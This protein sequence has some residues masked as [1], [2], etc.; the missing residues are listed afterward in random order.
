MTQSF[1]FKKIAMN[2]SPSFPLAIILV[3][4]CFNPLHPPNTLPERFTMNCGPTQ[5]HT[6]LHQL[7]Y[8]I[9]LN[10]NSHTHFIK[11]PAHTIRSHIS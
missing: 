10:P 6:Q 9:K 5:N 1:F 2:Y 11:H 8:P 4:F 3:S 7:T